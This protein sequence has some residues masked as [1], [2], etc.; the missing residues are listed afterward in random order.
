MPDP[1]LWVIEPPEVLSFDALVIKFDRPFDHQLLQSG[2]TVL[3]DSG[4]LIQGT[5]LI[6]DNEMT[7]R[8]EPDNKWSVESIQIAIDAHLEDVAGNN[9][10][11]LLDHSVESEVKGFDVKRYNIKLRKDG[12]TKSHTKSQ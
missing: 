4:Q 3:D 8:F 11:E 9:F 6:V 10:R 7:W 12:H 2:I 1:N 5:V